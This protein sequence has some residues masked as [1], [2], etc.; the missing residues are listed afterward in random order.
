M[1]I[2]I[3]LDN[4]TIGLSSLFF[5]RNRYFRDGV[6]SPSLS[7][8][9]E[10]TLLEIPKITGEGMYDV[11]ADTRVGPLDAAFKI[12]QWRGNGYPTVIHHHGTN[13]QPFDTSFRSVF[14]YQKSSIPANLIAVCAPYNRSLK[15]FLQGIRELSNY[16]AMLAVSVKVIESLV[17]HCRGEGVPA[18]VVTGISL[19]GFITNLH[20]THYNSATY[21]KPILA[22]AAMGS[23]FTESVYSKLVDPSALEKA[24]LI[25]DLLNFEDEFAHTGRSNVFPLL[26]RY[27]QFIKYERQKG[28]YGEQPITVLD[29][30]HITGA[31]AFGVLREH[32]LTGIGETEQIHSVR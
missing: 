4:W 22:G 1:N 6:E 2:H 17:A 19:G 8:H 25:R 32:V 9:L 18:T 15:D 27:D 26:G 28:A 24:D 12:A 16:A 7:E 29:K 3:L 30:G 5:R 13:E 21:Y 14:P 31:L 20:H 23:I 10:A 11:R